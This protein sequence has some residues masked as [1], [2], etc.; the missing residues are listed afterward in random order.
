LKN[1]IICVLR[2]FCG[3]AASLAKSLWLSVALL[4]HERLCLG[5]LSRRKFIG[6]LPESPMLSAKEMAKPKKRSA[7]VTKEGYSEM[8]YTAARC[9]S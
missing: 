6:S 1:N 7:S 5:R 8:L 2:V 4:T 9:V 3:Y